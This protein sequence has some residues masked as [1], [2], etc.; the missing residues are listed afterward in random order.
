MINSAGQ[1]II[2]LNHSSVC[3]YKITL[4]ESLL[5]VWTIWFPKMMAPV[6]GCLSHEMI[7]LQ[8]SLILQS[9][10]LQ[11]YRNDWHRSG[12]PFLVFGIGCYKS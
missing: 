8:S 3:F 2:W 12:V 10:Y 7:C 6:L 4:K 5:L 11:V 9:R 1:A